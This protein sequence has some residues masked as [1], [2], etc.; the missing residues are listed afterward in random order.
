VNKVF[1]TKFDELK[2][3]VL[4]N[5]ELMGEKCGRDIE[6]EIIKVVNSKETCRIIFASAPSQLSTF[7]YLK[8]SNIIP[9]EKV[10][11]FH[12]DEYHLLP[13]N[14]KQRFGK[15]LV[16]NLF[17]NIPIVSTMSLSLVK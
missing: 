1:E 5:E 12:M 16:D 13:I 15:Y 6:K 10:E 8:Q 2:V 3:I 11:A 4:E 9:W 7:K 14:A 17:K